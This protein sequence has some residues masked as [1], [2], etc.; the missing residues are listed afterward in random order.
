[1][2]FLT[3]VCACLSLQVN[4]ETAVDLS[5]Y[6]HTRG[7]RYNTQQTLFNSLLLLHSPPFTMLSK[8]HNRYSTVHPHLS[9]TCPPPVLLP[10]LPP[11]LSPCA[12]PCPSTYPSLVLS[13]CPPTCPSTCTPLVLP[14]ALLS[15][16]LP[17]LPLTF[18]CPSPSCSSPSCPSPLC[19]QLLFEEMTDG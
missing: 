7:R 3:C 8:E 18:S 17:V 11:V 5:P 13:P 16:P 4:L 14:P 1:M 6:P 15:I 12:S 10:N 2:F 9:L 19:L